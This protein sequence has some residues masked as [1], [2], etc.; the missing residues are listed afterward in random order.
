VIQHQRRNLS[1]EIGEPPAGAATN[2]LFAIDP[3]ETPVPNGLPG[4]QLE[5]LARALK[6]EAATFFLPPSNKEAA[7]EVKPRSAKNQD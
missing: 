1:A 4:T 3:Q 5:K 2:N 7:V 6:V